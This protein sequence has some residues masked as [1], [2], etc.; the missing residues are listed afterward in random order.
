MSIENGARFLRRLRSDAELRKQVR[1]ISE[2]PFE[3]LSAAAGA[4]CSASEVVA[5]IAREIEGE[6]FHEP[7]H[8]G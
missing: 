8:E 5:A 2:A 4:S 7:Y 6:R 1:T 3:S